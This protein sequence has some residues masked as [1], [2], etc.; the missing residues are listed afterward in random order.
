[1]IFV[2]CACHKLVSESL[3]ARLVQEVGMGVAEEGRFHAHI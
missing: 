2:M 1:M 3:A